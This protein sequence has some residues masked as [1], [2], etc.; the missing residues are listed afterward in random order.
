MQR[1][2]NRRIWETENPMV[3]LIRL[4][5]PSDC[6]KEAQFSV[7]CTE[8]LKQQLPAH[9]EDIASSWRRPGE[10]KM[11]SSIE[12]KLVSL[13]CSRMRSWISNIPSKLSLLYG[14][15]WVRSVSHNSVNNMEVFLQIW[16]LDRKNI[17]GP[18]GKK[19]YTFKGSGNYTLS[20]CKSD[21][22]KLRFC[23]LFCTYAFYTT[24]SRPP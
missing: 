4:Y 13:W 1:N 5:G 12:E 9:K 19:V 7:I 8:D 10:D 20:L 15:L 17:T 23:L 3:L 2:Q 21:P 16:T 14:S 11:E 18:T 24:L 6:G 22:C